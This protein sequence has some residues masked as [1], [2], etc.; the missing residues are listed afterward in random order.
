MVTSNDDP[1]N[2]WKN[3]YYWSNRRMAGAIVHVTPRRLCWTLRSVEGRLYKAMQQEEIWYLIRATAWF[4]K[5]R[6]PEILRTCGGT[7][8]NPVH[9]IKH[10]IWRQNMRKEG[11][12][13]SIQD[14]CAVTYTPKWTGFG[15]GEMSK[16]CHPKR[17]WLAPTCVNRSK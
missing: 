9:E 4:D 1:R 17:Y 15:T 16:I 2:S 10:N 14:S 11:D 6:S 3:P 13:R 7:G 12:S 8:K 5:I